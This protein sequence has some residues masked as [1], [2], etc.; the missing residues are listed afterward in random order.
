M[1]EK[2]I[3]TE[4]LK[5]KNMLISKLGRKALSNLEL[6]KIG[7]KLFGKK[8]L[9]TR[10]QDA[11]MYKNGFQIINT[12][13]SNKRGEHWVALFITDKNVYVYD[14]FGRPTKKL[15]TI[16][17]KQ[18]EERKLNIVDSDYDK[19]QKGDSEICGVLCLSWLIC[20][21]KFGIK[22]ALKI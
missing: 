6:N 8:Y 1:K 22:A 13:T 14:S 2:E 10:P 15:L 3:H 19:E 16:L 20:V 21:Q 17:T 18:G 12:D 7:V 11:I 9:G 5:L 4:F